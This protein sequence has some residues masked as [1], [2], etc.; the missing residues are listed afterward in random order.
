MADRKLCTT[1]KHENVAPMAPYKLDAA[2]AGAAGASSSSMP[3][4]AVPSRTD[5]IAEV[6]GV[7]QELHVGR[8]FLY[9]LALP[10]TDAIWDK[11]TCTEITSTLAFLRQG[12]LL[13]P[14]KK[15]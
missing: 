10:P 9:L 8:N 11:Y 14:E 1:K 2:P 15:P 4:K 13:E 12:L 6:C 5:M 7:M 3:K